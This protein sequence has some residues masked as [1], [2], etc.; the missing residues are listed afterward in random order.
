M[1]IE[2]PREAFEKIPDIGKEEIMRISKKEEEKPRQQK[3]FVELVTAYWKSFEKIA[4]DDQ[5]HDDMQRHKYTIALIN[6]RYGHQRQTVEKTIIPIG[7]SGVQETSSGKMSNVF[8]L[9]EKDDYKII[10]QLLLRGEAADQCKEITYDSK[11]TV[12]L[13][14]FQDGITFVSSTF[15]DFSTPQDVDMATIRKGLSID[16]ITIETAH[17]NLSKTTK[18]GG[19]EYPIKTDWKCIKGMIQRKST[20]KNATTGREWGMYVISDMSV[21]ERKVLNDG[22]VIEATLVCWTDP[23]IMHY[24]EESMC[25]FYGTTSKYA[26][27]KNE[28]SDTKKISFTCYMIEP[29]IIAGEE[30]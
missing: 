11:Y 18:S 23:S 28:K 10:R 2:N 3:R 29:L 19:Q 15:L 27:K 25:N 4:G 17:R 26:D 24:P 22:T 9:D 8:I 21:E 13:G 6:K 14:V 5:F 7:H 20:G 16:K 12:D 30:H 1:S